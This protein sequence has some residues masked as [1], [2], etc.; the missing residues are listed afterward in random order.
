MVQVK[1]H[2][3]LLAVAFCISGSAFAQSV[4]LAEAAERMVSYSKQL[5]L[6]SL[7]RATAAERT[8]VAFGERLPRVQLNL[9]YLQTQQDIISQ[10]ND[11]FQQGTSDYPTTTYSLSITQPIYDAERFR[12]YPLA[13]AEEQVA[14]LREEASLNQ[15]WGD[16][17]Q[18]FLT[19]AESEAAREEQQLMERA[20]EALWRDAQTLLTAGR[21]E[22]AQVLA[23]Q[24]DYL[25][26]QSQRLVTDRQWTEA[27][28]GL[29]QLVGPDVTGVEV[30]GFVAELPRVEG[31][32]QVLSKEQLPLL[33]PA[34]Q[35]A[36]AELVVAEKE[37]RLVNAA[38]YPKVNLRIQT[39]HETTEGSLFGGGSEVESTEYGVDITWLLYE[40]GAVDARSREALHALNIATERRYEVAQGIERRYESLMEVLRGQ[41]RILAA[42]RREQALAA[43]R[44]AAVKA[45]VN[46]GRVGLG[47]VQEAELR[48]AAL[49]VRQRQHSLAFL[50]AQAELYG[51]FGALDIDQLN[52]VLAGGALAKNVPATPSQ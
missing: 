45:Q 40:G 52:V 41:E 15:L 6:L 3:G 47:V 8:R 10:D 51:L 31:L 43:K 19:A 46:S 1:R 24:S 36:D 21:I 17:I 2:L 14:V 35:L 29:H 23:I 5:K 25:S 22:S 49:N 37:L 44:L 50:K 32:S 30:S 42:L 9:N 18:R 20:R 11:T 38:Y 4:S 13:Q 26:A 34:V 39:E 28:A 33:N 7:E 16:L 27:L 48:V 12:Q